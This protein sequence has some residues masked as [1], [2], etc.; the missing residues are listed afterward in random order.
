MLFRAKF[1]EVVEWL[2]I[3]L[4]E[5]SFVISDKFDIDESLIAILTSSAGLLSADLKRKYRNFEALGDSVITSCLARL[6]VLHTDREVQY[7][8]ELRS[9]YT[10]ASYQSSLFVRSPFFKFVG[11]MSG[12]DPETGKAGSNAL[13]VWMAFL[14]MFLDQSQVTIVCLALGMFP[15]LFATG[16]GFKYINIDEDVFHDCDNDEIPRFDQCRVSEVKDVAYDEELRVMSEVDARKRVNDRGLHQHRVQG[17][18]GLYPL[19]SLV[20]NDFKRVNHLDFLARVTFVASN[21][22]IGGARAKLDCSS[23][24]YKDLPSWWESAN[25]EDRL[26]ILTISKKFKRAVD[27]E[28]LHKLM[29]IDCPFHGN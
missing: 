16:E 24:Q 21:I 4:E 29:K 17:V 15:E 5:S 3:V 25:L 28:R 9:R 22:G 1:P 10:S 26:K 2:E 7:Y 20:D 13:E 14:S 12:V 23:V 11:F 8:Q 18:L 27:A 6:I 19:T